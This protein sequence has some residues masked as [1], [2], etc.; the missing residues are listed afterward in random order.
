MLTAAHC[1]VDSGAVDQPGNLVVLVAGDQYTVKQIF[2]HPGYSKYTIPQVCTV[3]VL[4]SGSRSRACVGLAEL[5]TPTTS[6]CQCTDG[7]HRLPRRHP[8]RPP[9]LPATRTM[10]SSNS[11]ASCT[12]L[13]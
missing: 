9:S 2:V 3:G 13:P 12:T 7:L 4:G 8:R 6:R 1:M 10:Q 5:A 11:A